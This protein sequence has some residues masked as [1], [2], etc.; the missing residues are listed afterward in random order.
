[1]KHV[2]KNKKCEEDFESKAPTKEEPK[3][4]LDKKNEK[5]YKLK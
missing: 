2:K 5:M 4:K 1:M 3:Q